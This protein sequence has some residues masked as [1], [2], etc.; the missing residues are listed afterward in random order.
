MAG[1]LNHQICEIYE[2]ETFAGGNDLL[3]MQENVVIRMGDFAIVEHHRIRG[4]IVFG[5]IA[6]HH[7][8]KGILLKR[9]KSYSRKMPPVLFKKLKE[10]NM[11]ETDQ[12][13]Q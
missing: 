7:N 13:E 1:A 11:A 5:I 3:C 2:N 12:V 4:S 6:S 9:T 10:L 8:I